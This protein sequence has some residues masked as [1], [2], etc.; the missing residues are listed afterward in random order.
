MNQEISFQNQS[1]P[2]NYSEQ[3]SENHSNEPE[4]PQHQHQRQDNPRQNT[5]K[6]QSKLFAFPC[7]DSADRA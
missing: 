5:E 4:K 1:H 2:I 6:Q 7:D 3:T